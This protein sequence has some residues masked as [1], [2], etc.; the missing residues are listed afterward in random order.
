MRRTLCMILSLLCCCRLAA[1]PSGREW[2]YGLSFASHEVSK[3]HRTGLD[4]NPEHPYNFERD[5]SLEFDLSFLR[6]INGYGYVIRIIANDSINIDL[7]SVPEH[8]DFHDLA[9]VINE[10]PTDL[11]FD[12]A[13][14][15]L[16]PKQWTTVRMD[17]SFVRRELSFTWNGVTRTQPFPFL[18]NLHHFKFF[19]GANDYGRF[20]TTD[21]PPMAIRNIILAENGK[22]IGKWLLKNHAVN[23]VYDSVKNREA[24][25]KNPGWIIDKH[26]RW[27]QRKSFVIGKYPSVAF[28]TDSA[29]LYA[30][31]EDHLYT[32]DLFNDIVDKKKVSGG[33]SVHSDAN[34]LLYVGA[35]QELIN[36]DLFFNKFQVF[37]F[38]KNEWPNRD[39]TYGLPNYWHNNKFFNPFDSSVY[40]FGGYG[41]FTYHNSLHK[42]DRGKSIWVKVKTDGTIPPRYLAASGIWNSQRQLLIFGGYGSLSGKQ[43][44]SPQS[45]YDLYS[46]GLEDFKIQKVREY[47]PAP[48]GEDIAFSNSLIINEQAACFYVLS[49]PKNKYKSS[50]H[51]RQYSLISDESGAVADSIPFPFHDEDS[52]CDLFYSSASKELVAVTVH[53]VRSQYEVSVHSIQYPPLKASDVIQSSPAHASSN[54]YI[55][56]LTVLALSVLALLV[57]RRIKKRTI[58]AAEHITYPETAPV[59]TLSPDEPKVT[60]SILLFGGFQV[61]DSQGLDISS[62]FSATLK[63][64]FTLIL[65]YSV[66]FEK[67]VSGKMIQEYLWPDKDEVSARNNRNVNVKKLRTLLHEIGNIS[68]DNNNSYL[69]LN[70]DEHVFCDYQSVFR[71]LNHPHS[72]EE[73][74][75]ING[76]IRVVK[77]GSLLPNLQSDWLDS[78]KSEISNQIID[79]LL[80]YSKGLDVNKQDKLLIEIAD[81]IFAYDTINQEALIIK[82]SVLN[83]KG[84]YSLARTWYD[85]FAKEYKNLYAET[86][87]RSFEEV[88]S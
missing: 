86:Y 79:T 40:T 54:I 52:F 45:F 81:T 56:T 20:T 39:T 60:S 44:L 70:L 49:F 67:G 6:L 88:I 53:K 65:L 37:D 21:A 38:I 23:T 35:T 22:M 36:Y 72:F 15:Q 34:Q 64:L 29:I 10:K 42:Y 5:F 18:N 24:S 8:E 32:Y 17:F 19:F 12:Y 13:D 71:Y 87:P 41:H 27:T 68:L 16:Q 61:I 46:V 73:T 31:D 76:I 84:K 69:K 43:E 62:K 55:V 2:D 50:I 7:V 63:E 82:C 28:N 30:T 85:H 9:V 66:K 47:A 83:K 74:E 78:F 33:A 77:H 1:Q 26:T 59:V 3:D 4:L 51:L 11:Q 48:V 75:K 58:S 57:V 14:V 25:A 80:E